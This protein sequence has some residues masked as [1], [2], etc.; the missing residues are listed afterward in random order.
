MMRA[1]VFSTDGGKLPGVVH[2]PTSRGNGKVLLMCHG[3][4]GSKDGGGRAVALAQ[5]AVAQGFTVVRFDFTPTTCL[6]QQIVEIITVVA[7]C[8]RLFA[9]P[10]VILGRSMG[11][12]ASLAV[13]ATDSRLAGLCLWSTPSDLRESFRLA[14]GERYQRLVDGETVRIDDEYGHLELTADFI[15]DF[16]RHDLLD[17]V[18]KI[19]GVPLLVLHG[20]KDAIVPLAQARNLFQ[21]AGEPKQLTII[22]GADHHLAQHSVQAADAVLAWLG[23][24]N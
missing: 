13:A 23:T 21:Q 24:L 20:E 4:R 19:Q 12:S 6:T 1:I 7:C 3:F 10:I 2:E 5:R 9:E 15:H 14:L 22:S 18:K 11:G 16:A 17:C 8:R